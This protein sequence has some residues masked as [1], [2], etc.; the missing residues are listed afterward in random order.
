MLFR[1]GSPS[2]QGALSSEG[3]LSYNE[4]IDW[5]PGCSLDEIVERLGP[6]DEMSDIDDGDTRCVLRYYDIIYDA[7]EGYSSKKELERSRGRD[8]IYEMAL[9]PYQPEWMGEKVG[10]KIY[11]DAPAKGAPLSTWSVSRAPSCF[12]M[13]EIRGP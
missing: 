12:L 4:L 11:I 7:A 8:Q 10:I 2:E 5:A 9:V 1:S 3:Q 6:P 13:S